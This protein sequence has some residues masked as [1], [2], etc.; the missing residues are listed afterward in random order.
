MKRFP[1]LAALVLACFELDAQTEL[2]REHYFPAELEFREL[3]AVKDEQSTDDLSAVRGFR[4]PKLL[5]EAGFQ[6][7]RS[8]VYRTEPDGRLT[9]EVIR[10][11]DAK[12][13]YSLLTLLRASGLSPGPPGDL[14]AAEPS[15][16]LFAQG[17]FLVRVLADRASDL[18]RRVAVSVGNRIGVHEPAPPLVSRFPGLG[19]EPQSVRY[20]L[21]PGSLDAYAY[22]GTVKRIG[23]PP[24]V[25]V[26]QAR[27]RI[28]G[29]EG[30]LALVGFPTSQLA[31]D[32]Y[33]RLFRERGAGEAWI[34]RSGLYLKRSGPLVGILE[35]GFVPPQA[36]RLLTSVEFTYSIQWIYDKR[37]H[38]PRTV[39]GI[40]MGILGTVVRSLVFTSLLCVVSTLAGMLIALTRVLMRRYAPGNPLDRPERTELIRL[41]L[42]E[43]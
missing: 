4:E 16:V 7:Y 5:G 33:E 31:Q 8:R 9:I 18:P 13:S 11:R 1:A 39:W 28:E 2:V 24:D 3:A 25:E 36:E 34:D 15:G 41:K 14:V 37:H 42:N 19:L 23:L 40:P 10:L 29:A 30:T 38:G 32:Y 6:N 20:F 26:A 21:G 12:A 27:Y 17:R 35:G 43:N 22:S